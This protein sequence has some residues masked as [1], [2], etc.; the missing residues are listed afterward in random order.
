MKLQP[1]IRK[2]LAILKPRLEYGFDFSRLIE[3]IVELDRDDVKYRAMLAEPWVPGNKPQSVD[4]IRQQWIRIF[5][6]R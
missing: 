1:R 2:A 5:S 6:S 3:R 4:H